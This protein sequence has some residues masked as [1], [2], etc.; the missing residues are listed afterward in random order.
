MTMNKAFIHIPRT[1]GTSL[2]ISMRDYDNVHEVDV[3]YEVD[4]NKK[5]FIG[6]FPYGYINNAYYFTV[7]RHPL[8]RMISEYTYFG[9]SSKDDILYKKYADFDNI[10]VRYLTGL[11]IGGNTSKEKDVDES[12][13]I[14]ACENLKKISFAFFEDRIAVGKL[15]NDFY[16]SDLKTGHENKTNHIK[17]DN[18]FADAILK[19]NHYDLKLY[20]YARDLKEN[21]N[22]E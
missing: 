4:Y 22:G 13:F 19:N 6:H 8:S 1:G 9:D 2:R 18:I 12:D 15:Y 16:E 20:N 3:G 14:L 17:I 11:R 21:N 10:S 5:F 7:L